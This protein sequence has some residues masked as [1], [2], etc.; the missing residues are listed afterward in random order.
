MAEK[1]REGDIHYD[2]WNKGEVGHRVKTLQIIVVKA[3]FL[4]QGFYNGGFVNLRKYARG[5]GLV[6]DCSQC[7]QN[8]VKTLE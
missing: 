5:E 7:W 8:C 1:L 4:K 3:G 2:L 6:D